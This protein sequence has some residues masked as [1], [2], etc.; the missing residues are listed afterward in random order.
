MDFFNVESIRRRQHP[1]WQFTSHSTPLWENAIA[2]VGLWFTSL[3][4]VSFSLFQNRRVGLSGGRLLDF[5]GR[6]GAYNRRDITHL[7][8]SWT[9]GPVVVSAGCVA[10]PS[11]G[12]YVSL[13][14]SRLLKVQS[15]FL[16][17]Q[18]AFLLLIH[19]VNNYF[20]KSICHFSPGT[21]DHL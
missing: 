18:R 7:P 1:W 11:H 3:T 19:W 8:S 10:L 6:Q 12:S 16:N 15:C 5:V 21:K 2:V 4:L 9:W 17:F 13:P 20:L 14:F